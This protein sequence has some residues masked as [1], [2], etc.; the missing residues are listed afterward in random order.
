VLHVTSGGGSH[1]LDRVRAHPNFPRAASVSHYLRIRVN[2]RWIDL[3]AIAVDGQT[4]D[5]V[6]LRRDGPRGCR[7][8]GWPVPRGR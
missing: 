1:Q 5:H 3:R 8:D 7:A 2:P 4:I 6:R